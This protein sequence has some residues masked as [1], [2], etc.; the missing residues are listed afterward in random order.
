MGALFLVGLENF[1]LPITFGDVRS[2]F[3]K[4]KSFSQRLVFNGMF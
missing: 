3:E 2:C 1:V 4:P